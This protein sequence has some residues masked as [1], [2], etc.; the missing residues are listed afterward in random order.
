[1]KTIMKKTYQSPAIEEL[2]VESAELMENSL[3]VIEEEVNSNDVLSREL[4][5]DALF[6]KD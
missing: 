4:F 1:M 3:P 5:N 2:Y 6:D